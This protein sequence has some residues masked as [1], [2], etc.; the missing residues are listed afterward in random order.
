MVLLVEEMML[1]L[2]VVVLVAAVM[3]CEHAPAFLLGCLS[4]TL[5]NF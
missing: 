4:L 5:N 3:V 2:V 1:L